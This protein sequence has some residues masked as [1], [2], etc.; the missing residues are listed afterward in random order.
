[1]ALEREMATYR[2][3]LRELAATSEGKYVVISGE[4]VAALADS[5]EEGLAIGYGRFEPGSFL[6]KQ[7][8]YPEQV[9]YFTRDL[10]K[11]RASKA[12][13]SAGAP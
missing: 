1:M 11:R 8:F 6:V 13:S 9:L 10:G 7:I 3:K 4:N 5:L 2:S 12:A